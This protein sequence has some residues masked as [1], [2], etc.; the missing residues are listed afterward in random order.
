MS[1]HPTSMTEWMSGYRASTW[2]SA[3][4]AS[5]AIGCQGSGRCLPNA[6]NP[7]IKLDSYACPSASYLRCKWSLS[8]RHSAETS[9]SHSKVNSTG[10]FS[11]SKSRF[12]SFEPSNTPSISELA[13]THSLPGFNGFSPKIQGNCK[14]MSS[15]IL[16]QTSP[17]KSM[18]EHD[19]FTLY[20][21]TMS[22]G[23]FSTSWPGGH[24]WHVTGNLMCA[25]WLSRS[26]VPM[27]V[28]E[29]MVC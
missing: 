6:L 13:L 11:A 25:K 4:T 2:F 8:G 3:L 1:P 5:L 27:A 18:S 14:I 15:P 10:N 29:P 9:M 21:T 22:S 17:H 20:L 24:L 23:I 19:V 26:E 28:S 7:F 16:L 12:L